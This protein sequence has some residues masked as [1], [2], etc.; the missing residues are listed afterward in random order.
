MEKVELRSAGVEYTISAGSP[1]WVQARAWTDRTKTT[2]RDLTGWTVTCTFWASWT[3]RV[4][5]VVGDPAVPVTVQVRYDADP[6]T[7]RFHFGQP[8]AL[9]SGV[10][11]IVLTPPAPTNG[12]PPLPAEE[13]GGVQL[14]VKPGGIR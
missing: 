14:V 3:D 5:P 11:V 13:L 12:Q 1:W 7:G 10:F 6:T 8:V 4:V 9:V 2:P